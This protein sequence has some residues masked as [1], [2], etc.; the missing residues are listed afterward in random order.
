[1]NN[2]MTGLALAGS[3]LVAAPALAQMERTSAP[4]GSEVYFISPEDGATV[5]SPFTVRMGLKGMGVAPAGTQAEGTGHHHLLVDTPL[6]EV[7]LDQPLPANDAMRHFGGGQTETSLEL[8]SGEHSLQLLFMD[9]NHVSFDPPVTSD[10]IT[11]T[12]E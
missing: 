2:W 4:E 1:M 12:V 6:D 7:D 10:A 3:M 5:E 8:E 9:A 11:I